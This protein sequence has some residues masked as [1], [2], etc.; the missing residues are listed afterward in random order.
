MLGRMWKT[1]LVPHDFSPSADR[2]LAVAGELARVH[3]AR[4]VLAHVTHLPPGLTADAMI[5][6]GNTGQLVRVD[7]YART[8]ATTKLEDIA[9]ANQDGGI[10]ITTRAL[11]GDVADEILQLVPEVGADAIVMGTH[12]R[13]GLKGLLLGS[14][15]GKIVRQASVPV[16]TVRVPDED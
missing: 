6:D 10:E 1:L 14:M 13:S 5:Q 8:G 4:I 16:V 3:G 9:A 2:A 12:G 15:A 11:I 7:T